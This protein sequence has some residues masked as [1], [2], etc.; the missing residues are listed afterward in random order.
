MS[1]ERTGLR[2]VGFVVLYAKELFFLP[3]TGTI[4]EHAYVAWNP[5][6]NVRSKRGIRR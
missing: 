4:T 6:D 2:A 5:G 3:P 1:D